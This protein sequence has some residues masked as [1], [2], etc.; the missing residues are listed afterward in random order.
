MKKKDLIFQFLYESPPPPQKKN[1]K[2]KKIKIR[3][4]IKEKKRERNI[5]RTIL[6]LQ[7]IPEQMS[8]H[9]FGV[10]C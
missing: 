8:L 3:P 6:I 4:A 5:L 7:T 1:Q 10:F 2:K 9:L